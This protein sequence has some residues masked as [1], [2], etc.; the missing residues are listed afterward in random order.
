MDK[1]VIEWVEHQKKIYEFDDGFEHD[2]DM[3]NEVIKG[4]QELKLKEEEITELK[5]FA[6]KQVVTYDEMV[7]KVAEYKAIASRRF[8]YN[9]NLKLEN[10]S[11]KEK[12]E[13]YKKT[14]LHCENQIKLR[15]LE[16]KF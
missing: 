3:Y 6:K 15:G 8:K 7:L 9:I 14:I 1:K 11:L 10:N 5:K 2:V 4:L 12:I 16:D 13:A